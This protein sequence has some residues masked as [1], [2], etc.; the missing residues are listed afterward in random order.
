MRGRKGLGR[1]AG[2]EP[3]P[4][5]QIGRQT[6][7]MRPAGRQGIGSLVLRWPRE[8]ADREAHAEAGTRGR[9]ERPRRRLATDSPTDAANAPAES[10]AG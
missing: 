9:V 4:A 8:A 6:R 5:E 3:R 1:Q 7:S 2:P 10:S